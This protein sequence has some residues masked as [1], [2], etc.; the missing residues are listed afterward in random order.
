MTWELHTLQEPEQI[1]QFIETSSRYD[2]T[3]DVSL[4]KS[5]AHKMPQIAN[6]GN[7][8]AV[9]AFLKIETVVDWVRGWSD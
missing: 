4:D 7:S 9:Q 5:A 2:L 6:F 8:E 3:S 1:A